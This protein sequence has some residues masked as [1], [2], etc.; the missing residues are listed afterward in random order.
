M[1]LPSLARAAVLCLGFT[2]CV[3]EVGVEADAELS[4]QEQELFGWCFPESSYS[5]YSEVTVSRDAYRGSPAWA[6]DGSSLVLAAWQG[7]ERR[8]GDG[9]DDPCAYAKRNYRFQLFAV[10]PGSRVPSV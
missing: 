4:E 6:N 8:R 10:A 1:K 3:A 7:Y 5:A 9:S 2:A